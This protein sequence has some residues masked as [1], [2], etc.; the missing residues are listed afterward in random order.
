LIVGNHPK[1]FKIIFHIENNAFIFLKKKNS[2]I[3]E[4]EYL[5]RGENILKNTHSSS[6]KV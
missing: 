6:F 1:T 3:C 4:F 2:V 5:A